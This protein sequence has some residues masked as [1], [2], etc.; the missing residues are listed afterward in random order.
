M[1][2]NRILSVESDQSAFL[3]GPR[4]TGKSTL[5][6]KQFA[7][8]KCL[9]IDLLKASE[10]ERYS[11]SPDTLIAEVAA[12]PKNHHHVIIDEIQKIPKLLDVVHLLIE[13]TDKHFILTG[14]SARKLKKGT[15]NLLAG[16]AFVYHLAPFTFS[17]LGDHFNLNSALAWGMMPKIYHFNTDSAK[18][19][20]LQ[21]YTHTYL[22]E[23]VWNE[24][25]I[26]QLNPFRH[27]LEVA[28]QCNGKILNFSN[29]ARD[30]GVDHKTIQNYYSILEDTLLGFYLPA[31]HHSFRKQISQSPKF[32]MFDV[33]VNRALARMLSVPVLENNSYY[34]ELFEQF[35]IIEIK[36]QI[37]YYCD[38][39]RLSYLCTRDGFEI[40]LIVQ[41]PQQS[42]LLIEI[43]SSDNVLHHDLKRFIKLAEE[44][45][46]CEAICLSRDPRK[47]VFENITVWP[48]QEGILHFF[49]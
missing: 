36:K 9:W 1:N 26:R 17:E 4:G 47:K 30:T 3:F 45:P 40:D 44:F 12:M 35:L 19:K 37:Q 38:E 39:Y 22:K 48:W 34:G 6:H 28:A 15:A 24:Q 27:F 42:L 20:Y 5:L 49:K 18:K 2:I 8:K 46:D 14:S 29:I 10:E 31:F 32:Y 43:K 16:R 13:K 41:R 21:S 25:L 7:P 33:G 23:E 11:H